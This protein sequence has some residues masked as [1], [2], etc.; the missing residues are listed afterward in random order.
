MPILLIQI[1]KGSAILI[2]GLVF[3]KSNANFSAKS[4]NIYTF[5]IFESENSKFSDNNW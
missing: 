2:D 3:H 5:H 4:R 1:K